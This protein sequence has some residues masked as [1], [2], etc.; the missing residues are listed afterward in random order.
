[1][2]K[3]VFVICLL[4]MSV[5]ATYAQTVE[6]EPQ[7]SEFIVDLGTF[8][9]IVAVVSF[10]VTQISKLISYVNEHRWAK[11]AISLF[12][13]AGICSACW[14]TGLAPFLSGLTIWQVLIYGVGAGLSGCGLYDIVKPILD[15]IFGNRVIYMD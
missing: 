3:I 10:L 5:A 11:I 8:A 7:G 12:V 14:A 1:M 13:G 4:L 9:G 2:K 15:A 6:P